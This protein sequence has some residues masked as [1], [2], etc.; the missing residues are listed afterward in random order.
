MEV[1]Q[2]SYELYHVRFTHKELDLIEEQARKLNVAYPVVV[3]SMLRVAFEET[4]E[5]AES[6]DAQ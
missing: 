2:V 1:E 3:S 6:E 4:K 5:P